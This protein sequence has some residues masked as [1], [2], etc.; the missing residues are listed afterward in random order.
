MSDPSKHD[1]H[2]FRLTRRKALK[3]LVAGAGVL[4]IPS[5]KASATVWE[6]FFQKHFRELSKDELKQVLARLE[7]DYSQEYRQG[8]QS[9]GNSCHRGG[10]LRLWP[11]SFPLHRL[12]TLRLCLRR[13]EQPVPR[14]TDPLDTGGP[15]GKGK[16]GRSGICGTLLQSGTSSGGGS[17]LHAG[18]LPAVRETA[19]HQSLPGSGHLEGK[20]RHCRRRLQLVHR[21]PLLHGRLPLRRSSF[22]LAQRGISRPRR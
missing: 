3:G 9:Q 8:S 1:K 6:T 13:R 14:P 2:V 7:K 16:R 18:R 15:P 11:R 21:M 17:L 5:R 12:P 20:R 10:A 19:L 4:A 22:Q